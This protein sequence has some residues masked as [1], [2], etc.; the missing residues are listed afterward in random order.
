MGIVGISL[1]PQTGPA[2]DPGLFKGLVGWAQGWLAS[3]ARK[4]RQ[5]V[6]VV[7]IS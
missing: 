2:E 4:G 7:N 6:E 3:K 5:A 1:C